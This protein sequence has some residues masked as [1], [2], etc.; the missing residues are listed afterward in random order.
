M[1]AEHTYQIVFKDWWGKE[2][3]LFDPNCILYTLKDQFIKK[4]LMEGLIDM[5]DMDDRNKTPHVRVCDKKQNPRD[6]KCYDK[7]NRQ[8]RTLSLKDINFHNDWIDTDLGFSDSGSFETHMTL[9]FKK[10]IG[11]HK[12]RIL[13]MLEEIIAGL[14]PVPIVSQSSGSSPVLANTNPC[15]CANCA[16]AIRQLK[17]CQSCS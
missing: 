14:K 4:L 11:A 7:I 5:N 6:Q 16:S 9:V 1:S 13:P 17:M 3:T 2:S 15:L 8:V 12:D 10:G